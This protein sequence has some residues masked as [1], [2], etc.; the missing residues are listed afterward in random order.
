[1]KLFA[2]FL[3]VANAVSWSDNIGVCEDQ[4]NPSWTYQPTEKNM[5]KTDYAFTDAIVEGDGD[6][7]KCVYFQWSS[8]P[9]SFTDKWCSDGVNK[10][11]WSAASQDI[12]SLRGVKEFKTK[13]Y[14]TQNNAEKIGEIHVVYHHHVQDPDTG[15]FVDPGTKIMTLIDEIANGDEKI[16]GCSYEMSIDNVV[17]GIRFIPNTRDGGFTQVQ[18][19]VKPFEDVF[20]NNEMLIIGGTKINIGYDSSPYYFQDAK[21]TLQQDG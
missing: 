11:E 8:P 13:L 20:D 3:A 21:I 18:V 2:A 12:V 7:N 17:S 14:G 1:M 5:D 6:G 16:D 4:S 10:D 9:D 15:E 19:R